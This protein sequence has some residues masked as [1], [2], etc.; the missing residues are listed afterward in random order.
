MVIP[1]PVIQCLT[2]TLTNQVLRP[3]LGCAESIV[4]TMNETYSFAE[5]CFPPNQDH[6][7]IPKSS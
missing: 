5:F 1:K 2:A 7:G 4:R 3:G 6:S